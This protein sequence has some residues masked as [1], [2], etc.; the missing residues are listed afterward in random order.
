MSLLQCIGL[1]KQYPGKRAVDGVSFHVEPGEI[2]G[3]LGPNGAG[4]TTTI[5]MMT[6][7]IP[8]TSGDIVATPPKISYS[9]SG[10]DVTLTWDGTGFNLETSAKLG[11]GASWSVVSGAASGYKA[12]A[13]S[14]NA[15]FR[16]KSK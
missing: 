5:S 1:V 7:M 4:K 11:T 6:G 10:S 14:G 8:I 3:L 13:A 16:L 15:Y 9:R 12:S 2:V